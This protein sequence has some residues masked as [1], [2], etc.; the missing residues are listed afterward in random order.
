LFRSL[1]LIS[2][3]TALPLG[4]TL[5]Q[6]DIPAPAFEVPFDEGTGNPAY[7]GSEGSGTSSFTDLAWATS[8]TAGEGNGTTTVG[9]AGTTLDAL[10]DVTFS[11]CTN[12]DTFGEGNAGRVLS[13]GDASSL[14]F[15]WQFTLAQSPDR[16][17][18][19]WSAGGA[20]TRRCYT[21]TTVGDGWKHRIFAGTCP[22]TLSAACTG[23][24]Y[25]SG[26]PTTTTCDQTGTG[27]RADD[28]AYV[29]RLMNLQDGTRAFDGKMRQ[30][31]IYRTAF[32]ALQAEFLAGTVN[33]TGEVTPPD[34][35]IETECDVLMTSYNAAAGQSDPFERT[36]GQF[37]NGDACAAHM[38]VPAR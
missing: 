20:D 32:N 9:T 27:T 13:K 24:W 10:T 12:P 35:V 1:L 38:G 17:Q 8:P 33:C 31:R 18:L 15:T 30:L 26:T 3:L 6:N 11:W 19:Q 5:I 2:L 4:A 14:N 34:P 23:Q 28:S 36:T 37:A 16:I 22:L 21:P 29:V 25:T 7:S